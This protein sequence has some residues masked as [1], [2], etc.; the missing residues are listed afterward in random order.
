MGPP[1]CGKSTL[2]NIMGL[3]DS[4]GSESIKINGIIK[5]IIST[6]ASYMILV[7]DDDSVI[8]TSLSFMPKRAKYDVQAV[9]SPKEA[10]A[11]VRSV[12][13]EP[14]LMGMNFSLTTSGDEGITRFRIY[15]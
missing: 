15:F 9:A 5:K 4:P 2:L 6:F 7:I 12:S 1:G 8:R 13:P 11:V 14:V 3:P 10:M